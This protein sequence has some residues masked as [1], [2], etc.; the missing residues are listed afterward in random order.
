MYDKLAEQ[1]EKTKKEI[2]K[3]LEDLAE[4]MQDPEFKKGWDAC[5]DAF[6]AGKPWRR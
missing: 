2:E 3:Q 4:M 5:V 6:N 1:R